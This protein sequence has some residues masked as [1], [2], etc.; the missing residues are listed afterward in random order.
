MEG[1]IDPHE[2]DKKE[3]EIKRKQKEAEERKVKKKEL[4]ERQLRK[5]E[6]DK[7]RKKWGFIGRWCPRCRKDE[8]QIFEQVYG[9][10]DCMWPENGPDYCISQECSALDVQVSLLTQEERREQVFACNALCR[11][12]RTPMRTFPC[13]RPAFSWQFSRRSTRWA[14]A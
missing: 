11:V 12:D 10:D 3:E 1:K 2:V 7:E 9:K 14:H 8:A 6:R 13:A 4:Q 5:M